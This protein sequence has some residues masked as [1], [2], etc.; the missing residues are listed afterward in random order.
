MVMC[1]KVPNIVSIPNG[2][3]L[4]ALLSPEVNPLE[5]SPM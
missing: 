1:A 2:C 4:D 5:G 3:I